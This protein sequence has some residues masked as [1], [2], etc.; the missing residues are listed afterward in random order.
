MIASSGIKDFIFKCGYR[1]R[2]ELNKELIYIYIYM[3]QYVALFCQYNISAY[4]MLC[5]GT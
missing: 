4:Y 5:V 1:G 2:K 3:L